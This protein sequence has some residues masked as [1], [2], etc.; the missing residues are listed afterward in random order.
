M[1]SPKQG[2][3]LFDLSKLE[4]SQ[5]PHITDQE[6]LLAILRAAAN[7]KSAQR[8]VAMAAADNIIDP[9]ILL[10]FINEYQSHFDTYNIRE[11]ISTAIKRINIDQESL[12][13]I[14]LNAIIIEDWR[15]A[16]LTKIRDQNFLLELAAN[17]DEPTRVRM[18]AAE[19]ITEPEIAGILWLRLP[20]TLPRDMYSHYYKAMTKHLLNTIA[21]QDFLEKIATLSPEQLFANQ[22]LQRL[23][24]LRATNYVQNKGREF[25]CNDNYVSLSDTE[26]LIIALSHATEWSNAFG[27]PQINEHPQYEEIRR[28]G[29]ALNATGGLME[30]QLACAVLANRRDLS[31]NLLGAMWNGIG[32]FLA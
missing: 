32:K 11:A 3:E 18:F 6:Q 21:D 8:K 1:E 22:A 29:E 19:S 2:D 30:M 16:A 25:M 13:R 4:L 7:T 20:D 28:I 14:A 17:R 5:I 24:I 23:D 26:K 12:K 27:Y 15:W 10:T 9:L 31:M